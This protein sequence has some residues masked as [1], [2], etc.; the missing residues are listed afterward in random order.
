VF[1]SPSVK[2]RKR[3]VENLA[4]NAQAEFGNARSVTEEI[5]NSVISDLRANPAVEVRDRALI[6][7][8]LGIQLPGK[9]QDQQ[10][11]TAE[12]YYLSPIDFVLF[13]TNNQD[14]I[15]EE[16]VAYPH[17]DLSGGDVKK[18]A[19]DSYAIFSQYYGHN[20]EPETLNYGVEI[21]LD[22]D[23]ARL[24][25][26]MTLEN[27]PVTNSRLQIQL[28]P[29]SGSAIMQQCVVV[30]ANGFV[31][32]VDGWCP[33]S[34]LT[35]PM[36]GNIGGVQSIY[37]SYTSIQNNVKYAAHTQL[38]KVKNPAQG[39]DPN[40]NSA[41]FEMLSADNVISLDVTKPYLI[42]GV[43]SDYFAG[44]CGTIQIYG[45]VKPYDLMLK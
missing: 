41:D 18:H 38:A 40:I 20:N 12:K 24:R 37:T 9:T 42:E 39:N 10:K 29:S 25:K 36:E 17:I 14:V 44:G 45:A 15:T 4:L 8:N 2:M 16:M 22:H 3:L 1:Q 23:D 5:L 19:Y 27:L 31:F 26:N 30:D 43:F 35:T 6:F 7:S 34:E 13:E 33:F 28:I 32:N 11:M 21:C